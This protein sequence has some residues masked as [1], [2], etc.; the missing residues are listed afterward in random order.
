MASFINKMHIYPSCRVYFPHGLHMVNVELYIAVEVL[1]YAPPRPLV[2]F[3]VAFLWLVS[4]GTIVCAS[5]WSD[6][7]TPEKSGER[8]SELYPKVFP[9]NHLS[10]LKFMICT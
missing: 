8:Y 2:D 4:V 7:T 9:S 10:P 5:L 3:S 6:L 1:L